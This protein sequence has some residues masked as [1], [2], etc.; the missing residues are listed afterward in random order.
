MLNIEVDDKATN[1]AFDRMLQRLKDFPDKIAD[2]LVTWQIQD[3]RR[4]YTNVDRPDDMT[5]T[6][7]IWPRSRISRPYIRHGERGR[8]RGRDMHREPQRPKPLEPGQRSQRSTR[9]ILRESLW[10][11]LVDRVRVLIQDL[12]WSG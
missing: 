4:H 8:P 9:P 11:M 6:T 7:D 1:A 2:E 3:M 10:L 5:A 12:N